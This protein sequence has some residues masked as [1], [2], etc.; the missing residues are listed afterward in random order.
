[1]ALAANGHGVVT[2]V[3]DKQAGGLALWSTRNVGAG[4][5]AP[6]L[7]TPDDGIVAQT[8]RVVADAKGNVTAAWSQ[9]IAKRFTVRSARLDDATGALERAGHAE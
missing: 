2:W 4:W 3:E 9:M 8:V 6:M 7:V 1:M 5:S